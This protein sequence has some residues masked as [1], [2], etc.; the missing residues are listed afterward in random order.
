MIQTLDFLKVLIWNFFVFYTYLM[1][2]SNIYGK[3]GHNKIR[4]KKI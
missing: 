1:Y 2:E 3:S 4:Q